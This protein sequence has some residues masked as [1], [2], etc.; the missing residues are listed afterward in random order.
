LRGW[1]PERADLDGDGRVAVD[2]LYKYVYDQVRKITASQTPTMSADRL[3]G[4]L[5]VAK[6]PHPPLPLPLDLQQAV[7][8]GVPWQRVGAVDG[9][10]RLLAG[11][12]PGGLIRTARQTLIR[13]C[14]DADPGVQAVATQ[15]LFKVS[16]RPDGTDIPPEP[17]RR[18]VVVSLLLAIMFV[19]GVAGF[20]RPATCSPTVK[21]TDG[22]LS[23][24]T[25]LPKTGPFI[26]A[27]PA[28]TAG[29]QLAIKDITDA[30]GI[31][32]IVVKLDPANQ[33]DEGDLSADTASQSIDALLS[34][35]VDV[36][37][38]PA[39]SAVAAK[40]IHKASCAGTV[41]FSP[42]TT[43]AVLSTAEYDSHG[44]YFRT[45]PSDVFRS[46]VLGE[47]VVADGNSTVALMS[48]DDLAS[49]GLRQTTAQAIEDAGGRVLESFSYNQTTSNY[50]RDIQ[51]IKAANPDAIVLIGFTENAS[52]LAKMIEQGLGPK[53][54]HV[55]G[56]G[57]MSSTLARQVNRQDPSVLAGMKGVL[58]SDGEQTFVARI[59]EVNP[60]LQDFTY[61][62]QAYDAVVITA[63]AAAVGT[64]ASAAIAEQINGVTKG[65]EKCLDFKSCMDLIRANKDIDYDGASGPLEFTDAG[66]PSSITYVISEIQA[67]GTR[68]TIQ[69]EK[70]GF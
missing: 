24:G 2:E 43:A 25:L 48:R 55:Y 57:N 52:I 59:K 7:N 42:A 46:F 70:I 41:M 44:R 1:R 49:D 28:M 3:R 58:A 9:L 54:K 64:D 8:S 30:G 21:P 27:G 66:E 16:A 31:P 14:D 6:N 13:L 18:L 29:V 26:Y 11:D 34:G 63:L 5:Y 61:A 51:R 39:T 37:I 32:G 19:A 20:V 35:G 69:S 65:G 68:K 4:R 67:D 40:V 22:V 36:I 12:H 50:D 45:A 33:R 23:L 10:Q 56:A 53:N 47:L 60:E 62:A 17:K 15:A 38:G